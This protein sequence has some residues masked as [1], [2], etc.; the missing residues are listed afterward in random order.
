MLSQRTQIILGPPGTGKTSTLLGLLEEELE[1]GTSPEHIGFFTFTKQAVQEG[2]TRAMARFEIT[3]G[4]LP[5]FRTLHS[6]CFFQLGLS[7]DSVMSSSHIFDLNEKLNLRLTGS[8]NSEE[9]HTSSIS[10][11]D[12]LLFIEN[13]SRMRQLTLTEQWHESDE[14]VGWFELERFSKGLRLFK[15]DRLRTCC[16][17]S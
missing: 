16:N 9:G 14:A 5:Y 11:D 2:K 1:R 13:L 8:I 4:Q 17:C 7:K 12:R 10:K 15:E 6:L 3:N